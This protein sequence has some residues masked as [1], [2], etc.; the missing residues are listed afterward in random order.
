MQ[1][2][3]DELSTKVDAI[4][5]EFLYMGQYAKKNERKKILDEHNIE[6]EI[7]ERQ[8]K[9]EKNKIKKVF[10]YFQVRKMRNYEKEICY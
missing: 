9:N 7:I 6:G 3:V 10:L 8:Y 4:Q 5:A 1:A 2:T